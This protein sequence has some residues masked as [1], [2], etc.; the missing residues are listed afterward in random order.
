MTAASPLRRLAVIYSLEAIITDS[1]H[2][3]VWVLLLFVVRDT[4][5]GDLR[6]CLW[7]THY[8][9]KSLG[10]ALFDCSFNKEH[11]LTHSYKERQRENTKARRRSNPFFRVTLYTCIEKTRPTK[12]ED[13]RE[14]KRSNRRGDPLALRY[15]H[16]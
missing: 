16:K 10:M 6:A 15:K 3:I 4:T 5:F 12:E 9:K 11:N 7:T 1:R 13:E 2:R 14:P 8:P